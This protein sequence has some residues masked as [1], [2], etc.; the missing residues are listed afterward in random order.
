MAI[1]RQSMHFMALNAPEG[2]SDMNGTTRSL[3]A[4]SE[5]KED[6]LNGRPTK[7]HAHSRCQ[8][9]YPSRVWSTLA[10]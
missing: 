1:P 3:E 9:W 4:G 10:T 5:I 2:P 6:F 7:A 8:P